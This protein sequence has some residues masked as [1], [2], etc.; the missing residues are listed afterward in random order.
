MEY[1]VN[2][3]INN[4]ERVNNVVLLQ[5]NLKKL[6]IINKSLYWKNKKD[7]IKIFK[8]FKINNI[9]IYNHKYRKEPLKLGELAIW[10]TNINKYINFLKNS[11]KKKLIIFEDDVLI[12]KHFHYIIKYYLKKYK[13]FSV[14]SWFQCVCYDRETIKQILFFIKNNGIDLPI[15]SYC[16]FNNLIVRIISKYI[17]SNTKNIKSVIN[18]I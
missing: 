6:L 3:L 5:H 13:S 12:T 17:K 8:I 4:K 15:D 2:L 1:S 14:G 9:K 7:L 11:N 16:Y 10:A 18:S